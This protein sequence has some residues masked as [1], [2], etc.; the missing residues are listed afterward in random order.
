[1]TNSIERIRESEL[2]KSLEASGS[3]VIQGAL[4]DTVSGLVEY[5]GE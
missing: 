2:M 4:Y 5:V 1:M 3:V